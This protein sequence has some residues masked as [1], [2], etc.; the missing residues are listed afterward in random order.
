MTTMMMMMLMKV[1]I[2]I[3]VYNIYL[4]KDRSDRNFFFLSSVVK[5]ISNILRHSF[6]MLI[7]FIHYSLM[8]MDIMSS[9]L[10][11]LIYATGGEKKITPTHYTHVFMAFISLVIFFYYILVW[12]VCVCFFLINI[13]NRSIRALSKTGKKIRKEIITKSLLFTK[14]KVFFHYSKL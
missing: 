6:A 1:I 12:R 4:I 2:I 14:M 8:I 3:P 9:L 13:Y 11:Y 5:C 7:H 10:P